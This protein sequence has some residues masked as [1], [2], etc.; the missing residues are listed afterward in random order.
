MWKRYGALVLLGIALTPS[1]AAAAE[2]DLAPLLKAQT[3][4]ITVSREGKP[5]EAGS[6][7][8]LCQ[9]EGQAFILTARHVVY[10]KTLAGTTQEPDASQVSQIE[11]SFFTNFAPP[12]I[13]KKHQ[14]KLIT[15]Q[16]AG[17]KK[18]L[19][20]LTVPMQ[21]V[22]PATTVSGIVPTGPQLDS[23]SGGRKPVVYSVGYEKGEKGKLPASWAF[24]EGTLV[25]PDSELLYHDAPI[26]PGFS[27]GPLFDESGALIGINVEITPGVE[28]GAEPGVWYGRA[29]AI[30]PVLETINKWLPGNCLRNTAPVQEAAYETYRRAMRAVSIKDWPTAESLMGQALKYLPQEGGNVH[31]QGMRYTTYLPRYHLG[32]AFYKQNRCGDALREWG[33]SE[34]QRAIQD[35]KRY[36]K[37]KKF[38]KRCVAVLQQQIQKA[39]AASAEVK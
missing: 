31:L 33:R 16:G 13:E 5:P 3:V 29:L 23:G 4:M 8:L 24:A 11:I 20:L 17:K 35:D 30:G 15:K 10:G 39:A 19:F 12:I 28:I 27:G 22:L 26:T 6:G 18:D 9:D 34:T 37:L 36:G 2:D 1:P 32:L 38:Q 21:Q 14:E 25:R 7:V